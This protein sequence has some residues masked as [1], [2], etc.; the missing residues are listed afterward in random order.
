[1][2]QVMEAKCRMLDEV[3]P[4]A[5]CESYCNTLQCSKWHRLHLGGGEDEKKV[6][7]LV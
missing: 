3:V 5:K 2:L 7:L 6:K 4:F 1:M